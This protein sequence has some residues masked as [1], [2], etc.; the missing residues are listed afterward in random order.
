[1]VAEVTQ[2]THGTA[3]GRQADPERY[4]VLMQLRQLVADVTQVAQG[5]VH[6]EQP[7]AAVDLNSFTAHT[8]VFAEV[9]GKESVQVRQ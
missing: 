3:Q 4:V 8:H 6:G 7:K 5:E 2:V 1:M 9:I